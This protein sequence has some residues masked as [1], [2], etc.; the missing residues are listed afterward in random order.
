MSRISVAKSGHLHGI[1]A[2]VAAML[3]APAVSMA[4]AEE[5]KVLNQIDV[6]STYEQGAVGY[7]SSTTTVGKTT[8]AVKDIPQAITIVPKELIQDKNNDNL[9]DA[10]RNVAGMTFNAG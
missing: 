10:L 9:K 6:K 7:N 4:Q 3:M 8:Q 5:T 2:A 1:G